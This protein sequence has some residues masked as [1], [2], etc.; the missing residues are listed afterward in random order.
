ME[1]VLKLFGLSF[2]H[3]ISEFTAPFPGFTETAYSLG[4]E[5]H[6]KWYYSTQPV[7]EIEAYQKDSQ[8]HIDFNANLSRTRHSLHIFKKTCFDWESVD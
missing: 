6:Q 4:N 1:K 2:S 8:T 3:S 5:Q 7:F